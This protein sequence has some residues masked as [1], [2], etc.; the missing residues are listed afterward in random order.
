M[1]AIP[2]MLLLI[3]S[4]SQF[5]KLRLWVLPSYATSCKYK[6]SQASCPRKVFSS[7]GVAKEHEPYMELIDSSKQYVGTRPATKTQIQHVARTDLPSDSGINVSVE[8]EVLSTK[9]TCVCV[10]DACLGDGR[11]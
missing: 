5:A 6:P 10:T 1:P 7:H 3:A 9:R 2:A 4:N 8:L 11:I